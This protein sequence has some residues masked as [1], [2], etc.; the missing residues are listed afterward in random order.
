MD[1]KLKEVMLI[2]DDRP[3]I[4]FST[5]ILEETACC[6]SIRSFYNADQAIEFLRE[7][8]RKKERLPEIIFLDLNMPRMDGWEF[9]DAFNRIDFS[10]ENKPKIYILTTSANPRDEYRAKQANAVEGFFQK[11]IDEAIIQQT[12]EN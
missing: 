2:D 6:A 1:R 12:L 5:I 3:T 10:T 4:V 11:P 9:L 8:N 7:S